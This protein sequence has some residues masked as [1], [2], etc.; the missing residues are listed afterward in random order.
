MTTEPYQAFSTHAFQRTADYKLCRA[1]FRVPF[2]DGSRTAWVKIFPCGSADAQREAAI[3]QHLVDF[4]VH[5]AQYL[6]QIYGKDKKFYLFMSPCDRLLIEE[7]TQRKQANHYW[8]EEELLS[9]LKHL[10]Q[11]VF[12]LHAMRLVHRN[13]NPS[14]VFVQGSTLRLGHF[15]NAKQ[16]SLG[17]TAI[18]QSIRGFD[19]YL[20]PSAQAALKQGGNA[21]SY[22]VSFK[23][24]VWGLGL[25]LYDMAMLQSNNQLAAHFD[26]SQE[27]FSQFIAASLRD[28]YSEQFISL[29]GA[30]LVLNAQQRPSIADVLEA[31]DRRAANCVRC[32]K[33]LNMAAWPCKHIYC[34]ACLR[35]RLKELTLSRAKAVT[36][37]CGELIPACFYR[38]TLGPLAELCLDPEVKCGQCGT[39]TPRI[40]QE[41]S[42]L[43]AYEAHC[44]C[45]VFCSLCGSKKL[46]KI[47]GIRRPCPL[48]RGL[49]DFL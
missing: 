37:Y 41:G 23:D 9:H 11:T 20:T 36:C 35:T 21:Y 34:S 19:G 42:R 15:D 26:T 6:H 14:T 48:L 25:T 1:C 30:M 12:Q 5:V 10:A 24:D 13:I 16:V 2:P 4:R 43:C 49:A 3:L 39:A 22:E 29:L 44:Q 31:L 18:A 46:H 47:L 45:G 17:I 38:S 8:S 28:R 32:G 40:H 7:L 33:V 27:E